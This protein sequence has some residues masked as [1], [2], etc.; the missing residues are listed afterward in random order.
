MGMKEGGGTDNSQMKDKLLKEY[1]RRV[2][3]SQD[4]VKLEEQD[5]GYQHLSCADRQVEKLRRRTEK[6]EF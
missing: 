4:G 2:R 6:R 3:H 5:D 1:Y